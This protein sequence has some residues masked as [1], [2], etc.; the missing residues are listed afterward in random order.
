MKRLLAA[1]LVLA[2]AVGFISTASAEDRAIPKWK[3]RTLSWEGYGA[4]AGN[5]LIGTCGIGTKRDTTFFDGLETDS[6]IDTTEALSTQG[7]AFNAPLTPNTASGFARLFVYQNPNISRWAVSVD[8]FFV[9]VDTAPTQCG[10]WISGTF[11][12]GV[13]TTT[14]EFAGSI[15]LLI[16]S[17]S[18][19]GVATADKLLGAPWIRLRVRGDGNSAAKFPGA[20]VMLGFPSL[21]D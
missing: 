9:A 21:L 17:D 5:G 2:C 10:P 16:D 14:G 3:Y 6:Q 19:A 12:G 8:S 20:R 4:V 13:A 18:N 1:A 15:M 7:F 11:V